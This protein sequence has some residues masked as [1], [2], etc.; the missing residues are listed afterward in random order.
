MIMKLSKVLAG[1]AISAALSLTVL[2]QSLGD[3]ARAARTEK[4][5]TPQT[6][7]FTNDNLPTGGAISVLGSAP[8]APASTTSG[9]QSAKAA[10]AKPAVSDAEAKQKETDKI[11]T[12]IEAQKGEISRLERELDISTREW[13]LRQAAYYADAGNQ[14]RDPA[15]W[16]AQER[17]YNDETAQKKQA[18]D[19]ARQKLDDL[20]E[21]ARKTGMSS[22][23][24]E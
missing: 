23:A 17:K 13:K 5:A 3:A 11:K 10:T 7:V 16:A 18:L 21:Q 9:G 6:K 15:A 4:P 8:A 12:E 2:A 1:I 14:L 20:Q 22:S 19:D 24:A